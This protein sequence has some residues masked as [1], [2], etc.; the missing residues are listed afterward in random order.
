[1]SE[2]GLPSDLVQAFHDLAEKPEPAPI[3]FERV[4]RWRRACGDAEAAATWQTWSLLPP[5]ADELRNA[6][7]TIWSGLGE[8]N[9]AEKLLGTAPG[10]EQPLSWLRL[11]LLIQQ[12]DFEQAAT[13]QQVLLQ[14]PPVVQ[15][16][17]LLNLLHLWQENKRSQQALELL[18]P[19]LNWIKDRGEIPTIQL[20]LAV[21]DLLEQQQRFD[22][23]ETW[24]QRSHGLQPDYAWPLMR[25]G[26]QALRK[27]QPAV[28]LHYATQ[29]LERNPDHDYAP[30]LQR[31]ALT[32][33][34][35]ERSLAILD[36]TPLSQLEDVS[37]G[38]DPEP[39]WWQGC[40]NLALIGFDN[41]GLLRSWLGYLREVDHKEFQDQKL[42]LWLIACPDPLWLEQRARN[43]FE[44]LPQLVL[45]NSW[46]V[47]DEQWHG[48]CSRSLEALAESPYWREREQGA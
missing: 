16:A 31:K 24:W 23:A 9:H 40:Y 28:A 13:M 30:H 38:H 12:G 3:L 19:L 11:K 21:A 1:M 2:L 42:Q 33:L 45:I 25:L 29:V 47:W 32:A 14:N 41:T 43:L 6:L 48:G 34:G 36:G 17:D 46:P 15:I 39:E 37:G 10:D 44:Q 4:A 7:A 8:V 20:C 26:Q 22:E 18:D 5:Q 35:A 27:Q